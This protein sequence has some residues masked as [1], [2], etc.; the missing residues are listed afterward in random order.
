MSETTN[1]APEGPSNIDTRQ[2]DQPSEKDWEVGDPSRPKFVL[3][4]GQEIPLESREVR[5][6]RPGDYIVLRHPR[7]LRPEAIER[8]KM[9]RETLGL[10]EG[11]VI[12]LE[13]GMEMSVV[14]PEG[15]G[16]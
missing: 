4:N 7:V 3:P 12:V 8:L 14:R 2:G 16:A 5:S 6:L 11:R 1:G 13:E 9:L 10:P 15:A